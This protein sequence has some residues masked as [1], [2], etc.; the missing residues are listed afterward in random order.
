MSLFDQLTA[1]L[2]KY[3][4][5]GSA[6]PSPNAESDF[7]VI[8]NNCPRELLAQGLKSSF[9]SSRTA[10]FAEMASQLYAGSNAE[11]RTGGLAV[12]LSDV[13]P[14]GVGGD[15]ALND[16]IGAFQR[17]E[18]TPDLG[19]QLSP[20]AVKKLAAHAEKQDP[21]VVDRVSAFYAQHPAL[22]QTLGSAALTVILRTMAQ[23][24]PK[25][26]VI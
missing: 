16:A 25:L 23:Q 1:V 15:A 5:T 13:R 20:E 12:L 6:Q 18:L 3:C 22:I 2:G 19:A 9:S 21:G 24:E 26:F 8:C 17:G 14:A 10:G 11:V 4:K 7:E